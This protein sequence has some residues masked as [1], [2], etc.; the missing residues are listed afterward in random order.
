MYEH[1]FVV[2]DSSQRKTI[3]EVIEEV[4]RQHGL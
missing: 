3:S 1:I 2:D 4:V